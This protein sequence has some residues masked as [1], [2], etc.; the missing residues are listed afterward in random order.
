[1]RNSSAGA[2]FFNDKTIFEKECF[3]NAKKIFSFIES[4]L[5]EKKV[6]KYLTVSVR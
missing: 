3:I 1:M 5:N 6:K 4:L 2:Y